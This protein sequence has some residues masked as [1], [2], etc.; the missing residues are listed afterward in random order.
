MVFGRSLLLWSL[1]VAVVTGQ[2]VS[3]IRNDR[4]GECSLNCPPEAPCIIGQQDHSQHT[5]LE[6]ETHHNGQHCSCPMGE[7]LCC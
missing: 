1:F 7:S 3:T 6:L 2:H 5:V 4:N